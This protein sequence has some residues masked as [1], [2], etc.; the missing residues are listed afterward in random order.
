MQILCQKHLE[1]ALC[2]KILNSN[3]N[4]TAFQAKLLS[5]HGIKSTT[6]QADVLAQNLN[7]EQNLL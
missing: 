2:F 4:N 6:H 5:E 7:G 3:I 1:N